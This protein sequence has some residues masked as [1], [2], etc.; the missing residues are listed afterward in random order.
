MKRFLLSL[1]I[2]LYFVNPSLGQNSKIESIKIAY[3]TEKLNLSTEEAQRFWP[4]YNSYQQELRVLL[5]KRNKQRKSLSSQSEPVTDE[6]EIDSDIL[7]LRKRYRL[8]FQDVLPKEKAAI[9]YSAER[10]FRQ[11]LIEQLNK[12]KQKN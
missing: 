5:I 10:E 6:L 4:V 7:Q 11:Q 2:C 12:R 9:V 3:L 1:A 8:K